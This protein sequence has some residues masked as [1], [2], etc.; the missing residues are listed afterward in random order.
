MEFR[1]EFFNIFNHATF[2]TPSGVIG[3]GNFGFSTTTEGAN[4]G[5]NTSPGSERQIQFGAR[6][7]F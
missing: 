7:L 5:T 4:A 6:F 3:S 1:S 2:N